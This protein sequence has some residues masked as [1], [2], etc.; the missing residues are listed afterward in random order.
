MSAGRTVKRPL[1]ASTFETGTRPRV[2]IVHL[3][4]GAFHRA[5]QAWYTE[6]AGD[7]WGIAAFTG[8]S[9]D[10]ARQLTRQDGLY[11]LVERA[12][13]GDRPV[14]ASSPTRRRHRWSLPLMAVI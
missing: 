11:T 14:Q 10:A 8:R 12:A 13:D 6:R 7:G 5:H 2:R 1:N 9:P 4:L 3:G